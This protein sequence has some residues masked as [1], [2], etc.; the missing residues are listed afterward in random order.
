MERYRLEWW[1]GQA[2]QCYT[3]NLGKGTARR[4]KQMFKTGGS[5]ARVRRQ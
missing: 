1:N 2:W 4:L 5:T 3:Y